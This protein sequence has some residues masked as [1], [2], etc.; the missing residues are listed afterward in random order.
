MSLYIKKAFKIT[1]ENLIVAQPLIIFLIII[2]LT[3]AALATQTNKAAYIVFLVANVLLA[4]AFFDGWFYMIKKTI[5]HNKK[6][7]NGGYS[8]DKDRAEASFAL[9]KY[10]FP[11]VGEYFLPVTFTMIFY[12][13]VYLLL[14]FISIKAGQHFLPK[15][16]LDWNQ[17]MAAANST[18]EQM[19][20]Y[21]YSLSYAQLKAINLWMLFVGG[22]VSIFTFLTMFLF[23]ALIDNCENRNPDKNKKDNF[24]FIPFNSFNKN[25]VFIFKNFFGVLGLLVFLFALNIVLSLFSLLFSINIIL[26]V[27]GLLISFYFM[28]YG[29]VLIF[30]YYDEKK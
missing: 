26:S 7:E 14:L 16:D 10:F 24:L 11:G 25:L 22:V 13:I 8:S 29:F 4:T 19:Q 20:K 6:A 3:T 15:P 9:G 18:P 5:D 27:V 1:Q 28:T 12:V 23:P 17:F 30:L 2:S 21:V